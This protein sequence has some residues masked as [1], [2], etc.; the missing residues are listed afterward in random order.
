MVNVVMIGI[1]SCHSD[2]QL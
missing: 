1:V 2:S